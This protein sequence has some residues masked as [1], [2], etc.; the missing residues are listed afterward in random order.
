[1]PIPGQPFGLELL[2][3]RADNGVG[4][5]IALPYA[6]RGTNADGTPDIVEGYA[7]AVLRGQTVNME[8]LGLS[9]HLRGFSDYTL[10]IAKRD[11]GAPI[12]WGAFVTLLL[13]LAITFYLPRR[14]VWARFRADGRLDLVGRADRQVDFDNEFGGLIDELVAMRGA[15][16]PGA[17]PEAPAPGPAG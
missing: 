3:D 2:L 10:L 1:M 8:G 11:P 7:V 16:P 6:V 15:G 12:I 9:V 17:P 13:G 14:R 4:A 5:L